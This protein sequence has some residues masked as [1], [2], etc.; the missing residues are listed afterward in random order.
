MV[1]RS[2]SDVSWLVPC[3]AGMNNVRNCPYHPQANGID[4]RTDGTMCA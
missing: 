1:G 2:M 4:E 3:L